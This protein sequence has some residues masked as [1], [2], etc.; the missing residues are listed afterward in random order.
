MLPRAHKS[1]L[2]E[3][4]VCLLELSGLSQKAAEKVL[5][6]TQPWLQNLPSSFFFF[7][8]QLNIPS[9]L[10][11]SIPIAGTLILMVR[12]MEPNSLFLQ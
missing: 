1:L 11:V 4:K 6:C 2:F 7:L 9:T 3:L 5:K 8:T 10:W 12:E